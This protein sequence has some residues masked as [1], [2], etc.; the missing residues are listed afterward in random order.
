MPP[1]YLMYCQQKLRICGEEFQIIP[2]TARRF[3]EDPLSVNDF[4]IFG[5]IHISI[6]IKVGS[7]GTDTHFL[8]NT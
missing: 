6:L 1:L 8:R 4:D 2:T 3:V 5:N 7:Q